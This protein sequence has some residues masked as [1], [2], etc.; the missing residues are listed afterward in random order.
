MVELCYIL[1]AERLKVYFPDKTIEELAKLIKEGELSRL[2]S[3]NDALQ[4]KSSEQ[5]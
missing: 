2:S 4:S 3:L 5:K 1:C